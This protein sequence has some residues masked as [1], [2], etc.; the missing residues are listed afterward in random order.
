MKDLEQMQKELKT[1]VDLEVIRMKQRHF[2]LMCW[3]IPRILLA[4]IVG[5]ATAY[6]NY[7]IKP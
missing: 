5:A 4:I 6:L 7:R 3:A 1:L 2:D